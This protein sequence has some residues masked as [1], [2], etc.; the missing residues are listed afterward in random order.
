MN[1]VYAEWLVKRK[2]PAYSVAIIPLAVVLGCIIFFLTSILGY[3]GFILI[4]GVGVG[5]YFLNIN[6]KIEY[7]YTTVV[8]QLTIDKILGQ[9]R[10]KRVMTCEMEKVA[11]IAPEDSY[12]IG[13]HIGNQAKVKDFS[14][15]ENNKKKY[16]IVYKDGTETIKILIEPGEKMINCLKQMAPRKMNI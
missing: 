11:I 10:R 12:L 13:E 3:I 4:V 8:D 16:A 1:D 5:A 15:N 9:S 6:S 14:S 2:A 7:E